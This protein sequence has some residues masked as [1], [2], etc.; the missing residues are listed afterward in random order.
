MTIQGALDFA[1]R[2]KPNSMTKEEKLF[3][4]NEIEGKV[5]V[6]IIMKHVHTQAEEQRP[7]ID[8]DTDPASELLVPDAYAKLYGFYLMA[9]IDLQNQEIDKYNNDI[10]LFNTAWEDFSDH[11]TEGHMPLTARDRYLI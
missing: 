10:A 7:V 9:Q 2:M 11:W 8:N 3:F 6:E 4:L 1:D 5:H